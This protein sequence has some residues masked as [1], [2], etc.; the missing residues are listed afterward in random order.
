MRDRKLEYYL[1]VMSIIENSTR[2]RRV[3]HCGRRKI[4]L[5]V[6]LWR[7]YELKHISLKLYCIL[8]IGEE[9]CEIVDLR[10]GISR[11]GTRRLLFG[12]RERGLFASVGIRWLDNHSV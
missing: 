10:V 5:F 8:S 11:F 12:G 4:F 3:S 9:E 7:I 6:V 1:G 2:G